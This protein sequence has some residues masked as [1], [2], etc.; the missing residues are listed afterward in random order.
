MMS[1][2]VFSQTA[3]V[4]LAIL[5]VLSPLICTGEKGRKVCSSLVST[6]M[7]SSR[8]RQGAI[9]RGILFAAL[10]FATAWDV[11]LALVFLTFLT[12]LRVSTYAT[13]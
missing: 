1:T 13:T 6:E 10:A 5:C 7:D 3:A 11:G 12:T 2:D 9:V 4:G 8:K